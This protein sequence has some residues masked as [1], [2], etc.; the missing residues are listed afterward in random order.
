MY[1]V[2]YE[3][4]GKGY[5][6]I[7]VIWFWWLWNWGTTKGNDENEG[8]RNAGKTRRRGECCCERQ[9][10]RGGLCFSARNREDYI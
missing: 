4:K 7:L 2:F 1:S 9:G 8:K 3:G 6:T 10:G 5:S